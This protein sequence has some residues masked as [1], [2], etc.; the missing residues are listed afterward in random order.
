MVLDERKNQILDLVISEYISTGEPVGSKTLIE[1][2]K[3]NV[4]SATI[5]SEMLELEKMGLLCKPHTSAGR[6]P[7]QKGLKQFAEK[8]INR[9]SLTEDDLHIL[10]PAVKASVGLI[11]AIKDASVRLAEFSGCAVFTASPLS[12][13]GKF[14]FEVMPAGKKAIA[15]MAVSSSGAV[16]SVFTKVD[17]EITANDAQKLTNILNSAFAGFP[18][19]EINGVRVMLFKDEVTKNIPELNCVIVPVVDLVQSIKSYELCISGSSNLL[20]YPEFANIETAK[21]YLQLLDRRDDIID[22]LLQ[23]SDNGIDIKIGDDSH[24]LKTTPAGIVSA[25]INNRIPIVIGV[26]GPARMNY[27]KII[28]GCKH[29]VLQLRERTDSDEEILRQGERDRMAKDKNKKKEAEHETDASET[30]NTVKEEAEEAKE[31]KKEETAP[32]EKDDFKD[33]FI[34]LAA[35]FDNF[36]KRSKAEKE[37][38]YNIAV[39]DTVAKF[40]PVIDDMERACAAAP[41]DS[42]LKKGVDQVAAKFAATLE[43]LGVTPIGEKGEKFDVSLHEAVMHCE[44]DEFEEGSVIE[45]FQKGYKLGDKVVRYAKVKVN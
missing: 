37:G 24:L 44:S 7:S 17:R 23:T 15:I 2:S 5:R 35:D 36:K 41:E 42:P 9:Y 4:S 13:D 21:E 32:A 3:I 6:I 29:V 28:A 26:L 39:A 8:S 45:V 22:E 30:E 16:K 25:K 10:V 33:K 18:V 14:T 1:K 12:E 11:E 40:L 19:N 27:S 34:R 43:Q 20:S 38:I 31:E